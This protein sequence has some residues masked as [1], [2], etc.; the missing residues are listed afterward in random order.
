MRIE[1]QDEEGPSD[2]MSMPRHAGNATHRK[3]VVAA[4]NDGDISLARGVMHGFVERPGESRNGL[5]I[6]GARMFGEVS[7]RNR[8]QV[9][10]VG[11]RMA[12]FRKDGVYACYPERRRPH[13]CAAAAGAFLYGCADQCDG[14]HVRIFPL[15]VL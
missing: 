8:L 3:G 7:R 4:E 11:D 2:L 9:P 15:L 10:L 13:A 6:V 14:F 12:Q 5:Q 1:P